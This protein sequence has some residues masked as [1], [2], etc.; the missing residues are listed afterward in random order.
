MNS[1]I[2][3]LLKLIITIIFILNIVL[4]NNILL[5]ILGFYICY[6]LMDLFAYLK[7]KTIILK[8]Q[9]NNKD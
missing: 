3:F 6:F 9:E 7:Y 8:L 4:I 2:P 5:N 1:I